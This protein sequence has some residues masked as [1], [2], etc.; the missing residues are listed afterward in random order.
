MTT[1]D[2]ILDFLNRLHRQRVDFVLVGGSAAVV[3][4]VSLVTEDID[5]CAP[6]DPLNLQR[7]LE[8]LG[9]LEPRWRMTPDR[10]PIP[11]DARQLAGYRNLYLVTRLGQIDILSEISGIGGFEAV[12]GNSELADVGGVSCRILSVD[13]LIRSKRALGRPKDLQA[14]IELEAIRDRR[15]GGGNVNK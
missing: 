8:A 15:P 12:K 13:G 7:I 4:G 2:M 1:T 5:L 14:A 9:D 3:H 6:L 10:R 11:L